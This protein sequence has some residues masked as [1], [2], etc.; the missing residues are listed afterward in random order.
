MLTTTPTGAS[1]LDWA[2]PP[3]H[4]AKERIKISLLRL[5]TAFS[6]FSKKD[7]LSLKPLAVRPPG[8][9]GHSPTHQSPLIRRIHSQTPSQPSVPSQP[10][11]F[12]T[13]LV[14]SKPPP[15]FQSQSETGVFFLP[16]P[17]SF[18]RSHRS[19]ALLFLLTG[20][21]G[22]SQLRGGF[23]RRLARSDQSAG[24]TGRSEQCCVDRAAADRDFD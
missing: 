6:P 11:E 14:D 17:F 7:I 5:P 21:K 13:L 8:R 1:S 4:Q 2:G 12:P 3:T 10:V 15:P 20:G 19:E 16:P 24:P 22:G 23:L 9:L 18:P